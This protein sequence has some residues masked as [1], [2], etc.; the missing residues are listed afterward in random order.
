MKFLIGK[1]VLRY[2]V[3]A[4]VAVGI[5]SAD[6]GDRVSNDPDLIMAVDVACIALL[7]IGRDMAEAIFARARAR[8]ARVGQ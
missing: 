3:L 1:L 5:L 7:V 8:L 2:G 6:V 4:L